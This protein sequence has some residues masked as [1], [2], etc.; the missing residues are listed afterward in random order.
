MC[1]L[2]ILDK[3]TDRNNSIK[4]QFEET[5]SM[6]KEQV[7]NYVH[8]IKENQSKF[9]GEPVILSINDQI[10]FKP[11]DQ[12]YQ[13]IGIVSFPINSNKALIAGNE[14]KESIRVL[15]DEGYNM[16]QQ[17]VIPIV[18][19]SDEGFQMT[20]EHF[21]KVQ[22][23]CRDDY[24]QE[25]GRVDLAVDE[26]LNSNPR[27]NNYIDDKNK[28][29]GK[30]SKKFFLK[31]QLISATEAMLKDIEVEDELRFIERYW[32]D[33]FEKIDLFSDHTGY[34]LRKSS[35]FPYGTVM[36]SM[37]L[38]INDL[39]QRNAYEPE[40][41]FEAINRIEWSR[42]RELWQGGLIHETGR[43]LKNKK[44]IACVIKAITEEIEAK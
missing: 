1:P 3:L 20:K 30:Y 41:F 44:A 13:E 16:S 19:F 9:I 8:E 22:I 14:L 28:S 26:L 17:C 5:Y 12:R 35:V 15:L 23:D 4:D 42:E 2:N 24:V 21:S 34:A 6:K 40:V 18:L 31:K 38:V 43:I 33:Y 37:S 29:L 7:F 32:L 39:L 36:E 10:N 27:M 25:L 11:I